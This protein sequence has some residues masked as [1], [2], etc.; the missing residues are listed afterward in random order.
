MKVVGRKPRLSRQQVEQLLME[1]GNGRARRGQI[2][3]LARRL[4][5]STGMI[6]HIRRHGLKHYWRQEE[7]SASCAS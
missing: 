7:K 1:L 2:P 4:G 3:E 6:R 5:M